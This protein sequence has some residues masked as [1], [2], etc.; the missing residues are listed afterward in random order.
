[1]TKENA[2]MRG[3]FQCENNWVALTMT[4][5][6]SDQPFLLKLCNELNNP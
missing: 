4:R 3:V 6:E 1:M 2:N 5:R